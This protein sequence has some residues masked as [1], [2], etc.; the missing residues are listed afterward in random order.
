MVDENKLLSL[1]VSV[2][3]ESVT[4]V[5]GHFWLWVSREIAVVTWEGKLL[6]AVYQQA[7]VPLCVGLSKD[8]LSLEQAL[9][10]G[11]IDAAISFMT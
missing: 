10:E 11:K 5:T 9:Q 8:W 4:C 2:D 3:Q 7:L 1:T 6:L